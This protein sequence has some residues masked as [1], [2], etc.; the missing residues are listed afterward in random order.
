[1]QK[2]I[3]IFLLIFSLLL[4]NNGWS[5]EVQKENG[6]CIATSPNQDWES[7][8]QRIIQHQKTN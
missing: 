7:K 5:N 1:M 3:L 2:V 8:I 4:N 6:W